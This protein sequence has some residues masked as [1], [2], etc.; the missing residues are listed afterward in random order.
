MVAVNN[1]VYNNH[2]RSRLSNFWLS[3]QPPSAFGN[4]PGFGVT[5][6]AVTPGMLNALAAS[7]KTFILKILVCPD[8]TQP[9]HQCH[10][11]VDCPTSYS[12]E[13]NYCCRTVARC[14]IGALALPG[15]RCDLRTKWCPANFACLT[16]GI[17]CA[18]R[19]SG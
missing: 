17:C 15:Y 11:N 1:F 16:G 7:D 6:L 18:N 5:Q 2:H 14:P 4:Q 19:K 9:L 8:A 3:V 13:R 10:S 12:C